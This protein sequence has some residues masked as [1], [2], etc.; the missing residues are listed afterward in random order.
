MAHF[1]LVKLRYHSRVAVALYVTR[2][3]LVACNMRRPSPMTARQLAIIPS[4]PQASSMG[5]SYSS[6]GTTTR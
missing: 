1:T 5:L 4:F 2:W 6:M 3:Q